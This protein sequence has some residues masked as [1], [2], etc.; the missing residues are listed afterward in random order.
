MRKHSKC[1]GLDLAG[2]VDCA[3]LIQVHINRSW[4]MNTYL[5][6]GHPSGE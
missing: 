4:I 2:L 3:D 1:L 5:I 6:L